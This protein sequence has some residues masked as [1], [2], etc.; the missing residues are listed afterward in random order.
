MDPRPSLLFDLPPTNIIDLIPPQCHLG[1]RRGVASVIS[2]RQ[3]TVPQLDGAA[4]EK[5]GLTC[6]RSGG[7]GVCI[8]S[9]V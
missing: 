4:G 6:P 8:A 7:L 9:V 1:Y 5:A 2:S 3:D